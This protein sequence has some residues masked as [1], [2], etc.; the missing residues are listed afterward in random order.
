MEW[1]K[2]PLFLAAAKAAASTPLLISDIV[3]VGRRC[4]TASS[5]PAFVARVAASRDLTSGRLRI[6]FQ[7]PTT[8]PAMLLPV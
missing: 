6:A 1:M 2:V 8:S 5:M 7:G 3:F 4:E